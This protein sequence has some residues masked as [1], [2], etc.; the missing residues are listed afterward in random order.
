MFHVVKE[1]RWESL[2]KLRD[3]AS[4]R[5]RYSDC[6]VCLSNFNDVTAQLLKKE[7]AIYHLECYKLATNKT[8]ID[9]LRK[10]PEAQPNA[11]ALD[12]DN[13]NTKEVEI[14][15]NRRDLCSKSI[16]FDKTKCIICQ[17]RRGKLRKAMD[18]NLVKRM[19]D[20][21]KALPEKGFFIRLNSIP[22]AMM[23]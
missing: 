21:A 2:Q 16:G 6:S 4:Q 3:A 15:E 8:F 13:C 10:R 18:V 12:R 22:N 17:E 7:K 14:V 19:L 1:P 5:A 9:R 11:L 20:V 23:Q